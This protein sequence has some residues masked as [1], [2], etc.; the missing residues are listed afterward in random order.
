[1]KTNSFLMKQLSQ[2]TAVALL[3]SSA[4]SAQTTQSSEV[5][6]AESAIQLPVVV[7]SATRT[8]RLIDET[9]GSIISI[10]LGIDPITDF[11]TLARREPLA[12]VPFQAFGSDSFIPYQR[13]GNLGYNLRGIEGNR[14][15]IQVDGIRAPDEFTLGGSEPTGR[16]SL[17]TE[18]L[19]RAEILQ[20]SASALYGTDA[21]GGVV[22]FTT[23]N[24]ETVLRGSSTAL[25]YKGAYSSVNDSFSHTITG[26]ATANALSAVLVYSRRDGS[27]SKNNGSIPPNPADLQSD[28]ILAKLVWQPSPAHRLRFTAE[29][30][31]RT[32]D[33]EIDNAEITSP[34]LGTIER[35]ETESL[36]QRF[37]TGLDYRFIPAHESIVFD[38]LSLSL[39][40]QDSVA[41]DNN[42]QVRAA[43]RSR[44]RDAETAFHNDTTGGSIAA[45]KSFDSAGAKHRLAY[46]VESNR[47]ATSK[48]FLRTQTTSISTF[49]DAPRMADTDTTRT[50]VYLQ[51][52]IEWKL[53]AERSFLLIPG[54]RVDRF[55]LAPD[56]TPAYLATTAGQ[57]APKFNDTAVAPKLGALLGITDGLNAYA[58]YNHGYRYPSAEELTATFTNVA[59][60]Y[61]TIPNLNLQ[62]ETSD[63]YEFGL[64]GKINAAV[65]VRAAVFH[66]TY[67][68]FIAQFLSTGAFDPNF[69]AGIFQTRN[70]GETNI[71]GFDLSTTIDGG[72]LT[73]ALSAWTATFAF[74]WSDGRIRDENQ[75]TWRPLDSISPWQISTGL[76]YTPRNQPWGARIGVEQVGKKDADEID[77]DPT[78]RFL[79]PSYTTVDLTA[80]WRLND[81]VSFNLGL[82]NLTDEKYWRYNR[83]RGVRAASRVRGVRAASTSQLERRT[84]PGFNPALSANFRF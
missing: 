75:T 69:P 20:G 55:E 34:F 47:T 82:Y 64:K 59:F 25:A 49:T 53:S 58:Q 24:P 13:G 4:L 37:R 44:L 29:N 52:E 70:V 2:L 48:S 1:M 81:Q 80:W 22:S 18:L 71:R 6:S 39:Y 54:V 9:P 76:A 65:S 27:E 51:D 73:A 17:E 31:D 38:S 45:V 11:A 23:K 40:Q 68:N 10:P 21:L 12:D 33:V 50:G 83:V 14:V 84:A 57:S 35:V 28:A 61:K 56:N 62:P 30:L 46:G 63:S 3:F 36:T 19:E 5:S 67:E 8:E 60:G 74:G 15:L 72:E 77:G 7:I 16:N 32:V 79:T 42:I 43:P 78:V 26:A 41:K 66:N